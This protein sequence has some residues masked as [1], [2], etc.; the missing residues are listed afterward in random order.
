M[1]QRALLIVM[2]IAMFWQSVAHARPGSSVNL[3]ADLQ[4]AVLHWQQMSHH[5]DDDGSWQEDDS[6]ASTSHV[7]SDHF[8]AATLILETP[9]SPVQ[10]AASEQP[11]QRAGSL[12]A[13]P[14]LDGLLRPPRLPA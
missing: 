11:T 7:L 12:V 8:T 9:A 1:S 2:L 10:P 5:H 13:E 4:H 14:C 3:L 6:T